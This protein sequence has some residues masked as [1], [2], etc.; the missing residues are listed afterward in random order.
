MHIL[1]KKLH[2]ILLEV[3]IA[4]TLVAIFSLFLIGNPLIHCKN[5]LESLKVNEYERIADYSFSEIKTKLFLNQI[6]WKNF[7]KKGGE[8]T[9]YSL[10][11]HSFYFKE[12]KIVLKRTFTITTINDKE[13]KEKNSPAFYHLLEINLTLTPKNHTKPIT[14]S[15]KV[16]VKKNLH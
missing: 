1:K 13:K 7:Q 2:F 16:V 3:L 12:K 15:Y 5:E 4:L 6:P 14:R 10:K 9:I 8:K 11:N